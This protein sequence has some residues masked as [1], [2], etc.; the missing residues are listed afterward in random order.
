MSKIEDKFKKYFNL[1]HLPNW[2]IIVLVVVFIL[3]IPSF[4]E[5]Y[6]YGDEMIYLT[7]GQG[8]REGLTLYKDIYDNKPPL[9]YIL[10][11]VAGNLFWFK[12]ILAFWSLAT[13]ILF[14]KLSKALFPDKLKLQKVATWIF[15]ILTTIPL[16]EGNIANAEV[17]MVGPII[18][19]LVILFSKKLSQ[20]NLFFSGIL[21]GIATL[22]KV[23]AAFDMPVILAFWLIT[24]GVKKE[25]IKNSLKKFL[26]IFG[27][28]LF[29]IVIGLIWYFLKGALNEYISAAFLQN[30]GYL[31]SWR[32]SDTSQSFL[33]K[34]APLLIRGGI[35]AL[36]L[37]ILYLK[38]SKLSKQFILLTI[39]L[40]FTLFAVTLS[41][42]P[43]P[44]YLIQSLAP[45]SFFLAILFTQKTF[46]QSLVIIPL[47]LA[48]FTPVYF[49]FWYYPTGT[50]Y[51][52]FIKFVSGEMPRRQY[53]IS[54]GSHL[55]LYNRIAGFLRASI[56]ENDSVFIW[57]PD[58]QTIYA[59][60]R[61]L[62]PIKYVA[63]YHINDF[64][65]KSEIASQL[66]LDKPTFVI[67]LPKSDPFPELRPTLS[68]SYIPIVSARE[69][70]IW[71]LSGA[72]NEIKIPKSLK[73]TE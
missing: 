63:T 13:I 59:L 18:L 61:R 34:N 70:E 48:F 46:E 23:P 31:S 32:P 57:G 67:I 12:A 1:I 29:P 37:A 2:L 9:L 16:L 30:V 17:F 22:F 60:S 5:P 27:G 25:N 11:A 8:M 64:S 50:Y 15:A 54:F 40:L 10:A 68:N 43:Y 58:N 53:L 71:L 36:G 19:A 69:A 44:H 45:I 33:E 49:K 7:L 62:P 21:F 14:W 47:A 52:R 4:F 72:T 35:V 3:R 56:T 41:E 39:W 26:Y 42:R 20:Q 6:S 55:P 28:F 65:S 38:K 51:S 73:K 24:A 66:S